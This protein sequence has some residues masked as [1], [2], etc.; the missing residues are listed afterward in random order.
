MN[1]CPRCGTKT[2]AS[3]CPICF[4]TLKVQ[5]AADFMPNEAWH[6]VSVEEMRSLPPFVC[7]KCSGRALMKSSMNRFR[8]GNCGVMLSTPKTASDEEIKNA[9]DIT[10][11]D[12]AQNTVQPDEPQEKHYFDPVTE[13]PD[14]RFNPATQYKPFDPDQTRIDLDP[15]PEK[16]D[17]KVPPFDGYEAVQM[18]K[19]KKGLTRGWLIAILCGIVMLFTVG[20][21]IALAV[22]GF[23]KNDDTWSDIITDPF[24]EFDEDLFSDIPG[25]YDDDTYSDIFGDNSQG[26]PF[27]NG[28]ADPFGEETDDPLY[29]N[30]C[31]RAEYDKLKTGMTYGQISMIIGGD[32]ADF[33]DT[34]DENGN[35][36]TVFQWVT[37][38][39][40]GYIAVKFIDGK[41]DDFY[42]GGY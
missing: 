15:I 35:A 32:A 33:Y 40:N 19:K 16:E 4:T 36:C 29:P 3:V 5:P 12:T 22:D 8:C 13:N 37:E 39:G 26:N 42:A 20:T 41:A 28:T 1:V 10:A 21:G 2:N 11:Q 9:A 25:L 34:T 24:S 14:Y 27:D 23:V 38:N 6:Y 17:T 18:P 30:G 31:S 7:P